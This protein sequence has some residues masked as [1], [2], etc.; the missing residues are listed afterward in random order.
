MLKSVFAIFVFQ[1]IGEMLQKYFAL[2]IPGPVLGLLLLLSALLLLDRFGS[3]AG[4]AFKQDLAGTT[5]TLLGHLPLLFVPIGVG[6]VMHLSSLQGQLLA[7]L[8]VIFIGTVSTVA[9]SALLMERMQNRG[10]RDE[11]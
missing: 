11:R 4:A 6:V 1:L 8:G 10:R 9:F 5:Q 2:T 3:G 7:V